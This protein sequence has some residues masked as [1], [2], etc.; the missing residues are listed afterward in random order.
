MKLNNEYVIGGSPRRAK[1][2]R[3]DNGL[4]TIEIDEYIATSQNGCKY[5][6]ILRFPNAKL[7]EWITEQ[8]GVIDFNE[9]GIK[10]FS[11]QDGASNS[12]FELVIPEKL[13]DSFCCE[14]Q[15]LIQKE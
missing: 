11:A 15:L 12:I 13:R 10:L 3:N 14:S 2:W 9:E 1:Y 4:Y 8:N 5:K 6:A 7:P